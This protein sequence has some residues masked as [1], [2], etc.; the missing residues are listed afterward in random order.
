MKN[1]R[2]SKITKII[3]SNKQ[4]RA[5]SCLA[6][7]SQEHYGFILS[8]T[9]TIKWLEGWQKRS[10]ITLCKTGGNLFLEFALF[11]SDY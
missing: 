6:E 8:T 9:I 2:Y 11:P 7:A 4:E 5:E 3:Q 10:V 1:N